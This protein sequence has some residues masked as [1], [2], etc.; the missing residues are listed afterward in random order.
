MLLGIVFDMATVVVG[1]VMELAGTEGCIAR[2]YDIIIIHIHGCLITCGGV[3]ATPCR[4]ES[5]GRGLGGVT[6]SLRSELGQLVLMTV[7][8]ERTP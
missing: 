5:D 6:I 7:K 8:E 2:R 3:G 4:I 1:M